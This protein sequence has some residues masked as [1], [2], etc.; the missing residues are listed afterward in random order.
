MSTTHQLISPEASGGAIGRGR[1]TDR[2]ILLLGAGQQDY[3]IEDPPIGNGRAMSQLF[4]REGAQ[5]AL[6]DIDAGAVEE[7]ARRVR[8]EGG[9]AVAI[10]VDASDAPELRRMVGDAHAR[11]GG[12]DGLAVNV[13]IVGGW[14]LDH[15]SAED[16]DHVFQVNVR[17]HFLACKH[18]LEV[19]RDGSSIVLT[20]SI[21]ALMPANEVVAY[22]SSK[23]ALEGLCM[24]LAKHA[25]ARNIR[26]NLVVPGLIDTS[27]GR[28]ASQADPTRELRQIPL[29]RQGTGWEVAYA[30][31]FLLSNEA[32]YITG[33]SLLVDGGLV[34]LR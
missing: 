1:L 10:V 23:A 21:A 6:A 20:S 34:T 7:T 4:A 30:A 15:T 13:G 24:W 11:L 12:L 25:A 27:L 28:L 2:K 31:A 32:S 8:A 26:V 29:G 9:T 22:H 19:M 14:G 5:V 16:W 3:N 17:A 18:A 33:H